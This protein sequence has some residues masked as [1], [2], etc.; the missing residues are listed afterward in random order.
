MFGCRPGKG[1][2]IAS[3]EAD[4]PQQRIHGELRMAGTGRRTQE[5]GRRSSLLTGPFLFYPPPA[6]VRRPSSVVRSLSSDGVPSLVVE[7]GVEA[8]KHHRPVWQ[9]R[10]G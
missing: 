6:I 10:E 4:A 3:L 7:L 9:M 2:N 5:D 1:H 8:R